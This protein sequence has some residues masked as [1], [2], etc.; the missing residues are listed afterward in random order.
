MFDLYFL[1]GFG[2]VFVVY[3]VVVVEMLIVF[4]WFILFFFMVILLGFDSEVFVFIILSLLM[5]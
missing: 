3:F 5:V 2:L 4:L 1:L